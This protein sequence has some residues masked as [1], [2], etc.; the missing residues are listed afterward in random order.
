MSEIDT[1]REERDLTAA[2]LVLGLLRGDEA[3]EALRRQAID[4]DFAAIVGKWQKLTERWLEDAG[5]ETPGPGLLA[6][7]EQRLDNE[8]SPGPRLEAASSRWRA[9]ALASMAAT[10]VLGVALGFSLTVWGPPARARIEPTFAGNVT[11]IS[12]QAGAPLLSAVYDRG[13]ATL[14]L[15]IAELR[16]D[17]KVPELWVI[18][19]GAPPRSLGLLPGNTMKITVSPELRALL[20]DGSSLAITLEPQAG[21]PHKAPT[22]KILGVGKLQSL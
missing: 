19:P 5:E 8:V 7:I 13:D 21:A 17:R 2:E 4:A 6:A 18:A 14:S 11:Q 16:T 9:W 20:A 1:S 3:R 15:R 10:V 12:D 22:G